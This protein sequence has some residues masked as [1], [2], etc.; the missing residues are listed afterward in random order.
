MLQSTFIPK[1]VIA[2][3]TTTKPTYSS[4]APIARYTYT[5]EA[6]ASMGIKISKKIHDFSR[7][8]PMMR[9]YERARMVLMNN[10]QPDT[11]SVVEYASDS[12]AFI[13]RLLFHIFHALTDQ[14]HEHI[15]ESRLALGQAHHFDTL[16]SQDVNYICQRGL[17]A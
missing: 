9:G 7:C 6:T 2:P 12:L 17:F 1:A 4:G 10:L 8:W 15:F 14:V 5:Y 3:P 11:F 13:R 16:L